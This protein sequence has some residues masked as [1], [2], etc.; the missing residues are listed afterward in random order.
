M[1][2]ANVYFF[3]TFFG[4][5]CLI[6]SFVT[7]TAKMNEHYKIDM[8]YIP[9]CEFCAAI[10]LWKKQKL[11]ITDGYKTLQ[12]AT[13]INQYLGDIS[14]ALDV[15]DNFIDFGSILLSYFLFR[16]TS[17]ILFVYIYLREN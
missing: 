7:V 16:Q 3:L 5:F 2:A 1:C 6:Y 13:D 14:S 17:Q 4:Y 8:H 12:M 9:E 10:L 11:M 15:L